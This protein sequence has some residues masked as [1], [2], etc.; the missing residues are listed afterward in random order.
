MVTLKVQSLNDIIAAYCQSLG[1]EGR[2]LQTAVKVIADRFGGQLNTEDVIASL[3]KMLLSNIKKYLPDGHLNA[4]QKV[5]IFKAVFLMN[6]GAKKWGSAIFEE[7]ELPDALKKA[8]AEH[9][10]SVVPEFKVSHMEPQ[11]IETPNPL[12]LFGKIVN[13]FHKG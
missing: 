8:L 6:D 3:D 2:A 1:Y 9:K 11:K 7:K 4:Y 13:L 12:S 5:A 10:L